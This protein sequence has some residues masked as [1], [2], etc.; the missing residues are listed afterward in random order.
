MLAST[1]CSPFNKQSPVLKSRASNLRGRSK[2][3]H[4]SAGAAAQ[5]NKRC[6][7]V[8]RSGGESVDNLLST[9]R[10]SASVY[11]LLTVKAEVDF[12]VCSQFCKT[13]QV[14]GEIAALAASLLWPLE[15]QSFCILGGCPVLLGLVVIGVQ[16]PCTLTHK[17]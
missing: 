15:F 14:C 3:F 6:L 8:P 4:P 2:P 16:F 1:H 13:T 9:I 17:R 7:F 11:K 5:V 10:T 12:T